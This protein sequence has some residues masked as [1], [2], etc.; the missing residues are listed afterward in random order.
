MAS[1]SRALALL[2][3]TCCGRESFWLRLSSSNSSR[4]VSA[5]CE[6]PPIRWLALVPPFL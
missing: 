5:S 4:K 3:R 2:A 1:P 6:E